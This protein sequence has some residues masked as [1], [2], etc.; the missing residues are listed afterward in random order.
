MNPNSQ[1]TFRA[2]AKNEVF[3]REELS[4][5]HLPIMPIATMKRDMMVTITSY[6]LKSA[7]DFSTSFCIGASLRSGAAAGFEGL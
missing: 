7:N 3:K 5:T 6:S 4:V 2:R 1:F